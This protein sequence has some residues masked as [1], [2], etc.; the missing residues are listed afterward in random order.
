M[1]EK[2]KKHKVPK[3]RLENI[4]HLLVMGGAGEDVA[5]KVISDRNLLEKYRLLEKKGCNPIEITFIMQDIV[6]YS[7]DKSYLEALNR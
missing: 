3:K 6:A 5:N 7:D 4:Y 2:I 1:K